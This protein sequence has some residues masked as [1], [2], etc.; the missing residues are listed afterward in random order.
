MNN[1]V[2]LLHYHLA[3]ASLIDRLFYDN[4]ATVMI[5]YGGFLGTGKSA[6]DIKTMAEALGSHPGWE[7][8]EPDYEAVKSHL[9]F[10]PKDF[11]DRVLKMNKREKCITWDDMGLWLFVLDWYDPFV[12]AVCKY[13]NVARTD[14]ALIK[15]NTPSPKMVAKRIQTF[16]ELIR[17]KIT[18]LG[19]NIKNPSKP[20]RATAYQ[21]WTTPDLRKTGV[22]KLFRDTYSAMMPDD[23][24]FKWYEPLRRRYTT[25]AKELMQKELTKLKKR[26]KEEVVEKGFQEVMPEP[27][28]VKELE[29]VIQQLENGKP[30]LNS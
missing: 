23:F 25:V 12:K 5:T 4:E 13:L 30:R 16:P 8:N 20:R 27:E 15:G 14:F 1:G 9:V 21:V 6:Y 19:S 29:E 17:V 10:P 28:R 18:K 3:G 11:V 22:R 26:D 7:D 24:Y 2:V